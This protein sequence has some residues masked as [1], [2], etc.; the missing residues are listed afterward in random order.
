MVLP[1]CSIAV[2]AGLCL[3]WPLGYKTIFML[4]SA[5]NCWHFNI[6]EQEVEKEKIFYNLRS[7]L[8]TGQVLLDKVH[9]APNIELF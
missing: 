2:R 4:N 5:N 7:W 1:L 6:Y 8:E 9:K 3:T